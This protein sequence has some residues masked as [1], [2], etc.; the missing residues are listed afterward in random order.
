MIQYAGN[1]FN[2][3]GVF[4]AMVVLA[5]VALTTEVLVTALENRLIRW[6][7]NTAGEVTI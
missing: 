4:A 6:R 3:N 1:T 5:V 2:A 7:P